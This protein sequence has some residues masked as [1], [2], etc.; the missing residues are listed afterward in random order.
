LRDN[1]RAKGSVLM[2]EIR[3]TEV[4]E[5]WLDLLETENV[6]LVILDPYNDR[7]MV[8]AMRSQ[9]GWDIDTDDE[10]LLVFTRTGENCD[11]HP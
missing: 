9:P 3:K 2:N 5:S 4:D 1:I 8:K 6:Q 11:F 10:E 7:D